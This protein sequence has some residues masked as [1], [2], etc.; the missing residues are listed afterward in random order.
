M[1]MRGHITQSY[2]DLKRSCNFITFV[3]NGLQQ[4]EQRPCIVYTRRS[5]RFGYAIFWGVCYG[6]SLHI[7]CTNSHFA[8]LLLLCVCAVRMTLAVKTEAILNW[9]RCSGT[10]NDTTEHQRKYTK[11]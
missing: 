2:G 8:L 6:F 3:G 7:S 11:H 9:P 10:R 1:F 4:P 5:L